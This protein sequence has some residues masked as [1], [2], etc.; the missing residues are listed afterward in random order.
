[1]PSTFLLVLNNIINFNIVFINFKIYVNAFY[2]DMRRGWLAVMVGGL[3]L[4]VMLVL[5]QECTAEH[6]SDIITNLTTVN[7]DNELAIKPHLVMFYVPG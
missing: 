2:L 5:L 7:F 3:R 1:M 4:P 6:H